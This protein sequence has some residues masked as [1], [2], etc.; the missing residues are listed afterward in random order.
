MKLEMV[1]VVL[2]LSWEGSFGQRSDI[3]FGKISKEEIEMNHYNMDTTAKAAVLYDVGYFRSSNF[4]FTRHLRIKIFDHGGTGFGNFVIQ[5]PDKSFIKGITFNLEGGTVSETKLTNDHIYLERIIEDFELYKIFFPNVKPGSVI[6]LEYSHRGLPFEWRFQNVI[7]VIYNE[8]TLEPT[9]YIK[10][11]KVFYGLEPVKMVKENKWVAENIPALSVEPHMSHYS[12]YLTRFE[13]ELNS[14]FYPGYLYREFATSWQK[15]G[16]RLLE[17]ID[18]GEVI[19]GC[20]FLNDKGKEL[21][22][23]TLN[24]REKIYE[25]FRYIHENI[26][27]NS[28]ES[29]FVTK[30]YKENFLK[31]HSG[32]SAEVNLLL[33][34]LLKKSGIEVEPVVLSTR[35][36]GILNPSSASLRKINYV[37]GSVKINGETVLLDATSPHSIPGV[38]PTRC[39]NVSGWVVH[40]TAGYWVDLNQGY[41]E[42][43]KRFVRIYPDDNNQFFAEVS[44][45]FEEYAYLDW[46]EKFEDEGSEEEYAKYFVVNSKN[47]GIED[48]SLKLNNTEDLKSI[49]I[50]SINISNSDYVQDIGRELLLNPFV[51]N[52]IEENPFKSESRK[53]P[54]DFIYPKHHSAVIS[55]SLPEGYSVNKLPNSHRMVTE[56]GTAK[57]ELYYQLSSNMINIKYDLRINETIFPEDQYSIIKNFYG[58]LLRIIN[59]PIE[60]NK[61]T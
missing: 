47:L 27:W 20:A 48:Y 34:A 33:I 51:L 36:N 14:V 56:G 45:T 38:L 18:F 1:L 8:L 29:A 35:D 23:S 52:E 16:E 15:V 39:L 41:G 50:V 57:F 12:N 49:D 53:F 13:M 10:F 60:L 44:N 3:K 55:I 25:A 26:K 5:A 46:V 4:T 42:I 9:N 30:A 58:E 32:N 28:I 43:K 6:D 11:K 54:I 21:E 17:F 61:K 31:N 40:K 24:D 22:K 37:I 2:I 19:K 59:Q 7:P